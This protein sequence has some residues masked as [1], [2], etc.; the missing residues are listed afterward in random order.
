MNFL[1]IP[2]F[3]FFTKV[4]NDMFTYMTVNCIFN[5]FPV[6]V[7]LKQPSVLPENKLDI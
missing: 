1:K 6:L 5:I 3:F 2:F 7:Q 4:D